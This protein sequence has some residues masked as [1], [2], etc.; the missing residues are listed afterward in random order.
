MEFSVD[1]NKIKKKH[2]INLKNALPN[3]PNPNISFIP[4]PPIPKNLP[5]SPQQ[6]KYNKT[7]IINH[8]I[9]IKNI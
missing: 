2:P 4:S 8:N 5:S 3:P 9:I 7:R 6:L 1:Y